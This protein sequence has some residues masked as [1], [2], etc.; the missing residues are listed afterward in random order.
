MFLAKQYWIFLL[1]YRKQEVSKPF[2]ATFGLFKKYV[3]ICLNSGHE[4]MEVDL[5]VL[6][7]ELMKKHLSLI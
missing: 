1:D 4:R 5:S 3:Q 2:G 7:H 6:N